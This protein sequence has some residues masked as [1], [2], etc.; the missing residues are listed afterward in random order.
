[1]FLRAGQLAAGPR[2]RVTTVVALPCHPAPPKVQGSGWKCVCVGGGCIHAHPATLYLRLWPNDRVPGKSDKRHPRCQ[3]CPGR[4]EVPGCTVLH[5]S[6][7]ALCPTPIATWA[8]PAERLNSV[9]KMVGGRRQDERAAH[10]AWPLCLSAE[11]PRL[12][13]ASSCCRG[14]SVTR[15][16]DASMDS[17]IPLSPG[18][19]P[20]E[21]TG[22][23]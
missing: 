21:R 4:R 11:V 14:D 8:T 16:G 19:R 3:P 5:A 20:G 6:M 17:V 22:A 18:K 13:G 1:M 12:R 2:G 15:R 10:A 23:T 9:D 7:T